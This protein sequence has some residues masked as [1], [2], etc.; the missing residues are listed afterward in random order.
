MKVELK[1]LDE[2][3]KTLDRLEKNV[4]ELRGTHK[5]SITELLTPEFMRRHSAFSSLE[6]LLIAGQ[7]MKVGE[8]V[9]KE[10]L[11]AISQERFDKLVSE[12]TSFTNW[13]AMIRKASEEYI[14]RKAL[15]GI[16]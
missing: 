9:T 3:G 2:V 5:V 15:K 16:K 6:E 14:N 13:D 4:K 7:L 1:G 12:K 8:H 10:S 11:D